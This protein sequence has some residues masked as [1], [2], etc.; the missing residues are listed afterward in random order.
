MDYAG[1][2]EVRRAGGLRLVI[3]K[4]LPSPWG[5]AAKTFFELKKLPFLV[6]PQAP[7]EANEE[8]VAWSGQAGAPVV[9]YG[10]EA[11]RHGWA[12]ILFL[13]DRLAPDR[14]APGS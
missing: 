9:A 2:A 1:L 6:A 5:Q 14:L 8:L 13:A 3:V 11:P 12:E 7:G 4:G 10:D